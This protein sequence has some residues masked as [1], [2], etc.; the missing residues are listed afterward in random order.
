MSRGGNRSGETF[1]ER[2]KGK[3]VRTSNIVAAKVGSVL[4]C[5][6]CVVLCAERQHRV[7]LFSF[8]VVLLLLVVAE[9]RHSRAK[10]LS[11]AYSVVAGVAH[12]LPSLSVLVGVCFLFP[13]ARA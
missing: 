2:S 8:F 1:Q 10:E 12:S 5:C 11:D 3:D 13:S 7:F 6:C 9:R 4:F